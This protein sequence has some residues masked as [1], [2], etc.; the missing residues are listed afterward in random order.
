MNEI[1]DNVENVNQVD[2]QL[3][4]THYSAPN[5]DLWNG[6]QDSDLPER[7]NQVVKLIDLSTEI[8]P[9]SDTYGFVVVGFVCD[10][11]VRRNLGRQGASQGP[12]I[13]RKTLANLP[14]NH[15]NNIDI[16][17]IGNINCLD[18]NLESAQTALGQVVELIL[19]S[20]Y[21]PIVLGGGHE[22]AW[23][24]Y[25]G[26]SN[27]DYAENL[28]IINFDAHFDLRPVITED[29]SDKGSSGT[30]FTQIAESREFEG[31]DFDYFCIGIQPLA[32]T[33]SLYEEADILGVEYIEASDLAN[34]DD[35]EHV[36]NFA[37]F[38]EEHDNLYVSI[39]LDVF[40]TSIAPGVSAPQPM[41]LMPQTLLPYL[42]LLA[43]SNKV[44]SLDIVE[45][46]PKFDQDNNTARLASQLVADYIDTACIEDE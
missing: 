1:I 37:S 4:L 25:Q 15:A 5:N 39:C 14:F 32:N 31:L 24:H 23:G 22:T 34:P 2:E 21:H 26:I 46:A 27:T 35:T 29:S 43:A 41:G 36:E 6:R 28:G 11:G 9:D 33:A 38:V 10:E 40:A 7:F 12:D 8:L 20:G 30:P 13:I 44:F 17:D 16:Y 18:Q 19:L 3:W 45:L 42:R